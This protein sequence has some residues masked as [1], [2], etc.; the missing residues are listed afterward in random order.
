MQV[1]DD[2]S[3]KYW[4]FYFFKRSTSKWVI[5]DLIINVMNMYHKYTCRGNTFFRKFP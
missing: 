3:E 4:Y 5:F 2:T 1:R